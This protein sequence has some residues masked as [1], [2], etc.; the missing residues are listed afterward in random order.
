MKVDIK[1]NWPIPPVDQ[2]D[3][4]QRRQEK[5]P[6]AVA[7]KGKALETFRVAKKVQKILRENSRARCK[8]RNNPNNNKKKKWYLRSNR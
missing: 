6:R 1:K 5:R 4:Q 2:D 3:I 8:P 7:D